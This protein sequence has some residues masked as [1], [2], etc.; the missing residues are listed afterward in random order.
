MKKTLVMMNGEAFEVETQGA[1]QFEGAI[2][3]V[4]DGDSR[5]IGG[6]IPRGALTD[7]GKKEII[8]ADRELFYK[9]TVLETW[10]CPV[11]DGNR[12]D[13]EF[14]RNIN[15]GFRRPCRPK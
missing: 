2:T 9:L 14:Y 13:C 11:C 1:T 4:S 6:K 10:L 7:D 3:R 5:R 15:V 8:E 12:P